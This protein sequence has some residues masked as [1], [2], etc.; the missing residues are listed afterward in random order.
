M[1]LPEA[2]FL[3]GVLWALPKRAA[4]RTARPKAPPGRVSLLDLGPSCVDKCFR[5]C[6]L[7]PSPHFKSKLVV[8]L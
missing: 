4:V 6:S 5:E 1:C 2:E 8:I 7:E 3:R